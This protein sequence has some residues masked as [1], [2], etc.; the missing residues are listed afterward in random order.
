MRC[1]KRAATRLAVG[2]ATRTHFPPAVFSH[3]K[4]VALTH[5]LRSGLSLKQ[6]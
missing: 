1:S 2:H 3:S 6:I 5:Y 4:T